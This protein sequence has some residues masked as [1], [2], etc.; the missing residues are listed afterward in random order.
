MCGDESKQ[1]ERYIT[2]LM[3]PSGVAF[4][5]RIDFMAVTDEERRAQLAGQLDQARAAEI[6]GHLIDACNTLNLRTMHGTA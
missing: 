6:A 5:A 4:L 1:F 2:L 3:Q